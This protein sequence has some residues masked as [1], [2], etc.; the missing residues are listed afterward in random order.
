MRRKYKCKHCGQLYSLSQE[1]Q[2]KVYCSALCKQKDTYSVFKCDCCETNFMA[3]KKARIYPHHYC[4]P[5]CYNIARTRKDSRQMF[6]CDFCGKPFI[7]W[8]CQRP[9]ERKF[10]SHKCSHAYK[11]LPKCQD[12]RLI[13]YCYQ[14]VGQGVL[15]NILNRKT[16]YN[17]LYNECKAQTYQAI[18]RFLAST[19]FKK[20][21]LSFICA[22]LDGY[23]VQSYAEE[24]KRYKKFKK[25][26]GNRTYDE[27]A[28][29]ADLK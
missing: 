3:R 15:D 10:C 28:E 7:T 19:D 1:W 20:H 8:K 27:L 24:S 18:Q 14:L 17:N 12:S 16:H 29:I 5:E 11:N 25:F 21:L 23:I 6:Y 4:S 2:G 22:Y 9:N 13:E 26:V